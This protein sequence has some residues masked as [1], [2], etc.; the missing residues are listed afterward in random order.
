MSSEFEHFW[1]P[2]VR[3]FQLICV[4]HYSVFR[5][6]LRASP[7]SKTIPFLIYFCVFA[8]VHLTILFSKTS[9][10]G[11][12]R[13]KDYDK[14]FHGSPLMYYVNAFSV[15]GAYVTNIT[16]HLENVFCGKR[17]V[18]ICERFQA[19]SDIFEIRLNYAM[20]YKSW[21]AKYLRICGFFLLITL[22]ASITSF[23]KL[24][25]F[26]NDKYFMTPV[27]VIGTIITRARWCQ[28][29]LYLNILGD[30]LYH[31]QLSLK[32]HQLRSRSNPSDEQLHSFVR[33]NICYFR[34]IYSHCCA[35]V[36]MMSE[37]FGWSLI[38]LII[39]TTLESINGSYWLYVN[40]NTFDSAQLKIRKFI[41]VA[42]QYSILSTLP[43]YIFRLAVV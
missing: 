29:A 42:I 30:I 32:Q 39:K 21:R 16:I 31:L 33:E 18:E 3:I 12:F 35:I 43:L 11:S 25:H 10:V 19:I 26:F 36:T 9:R 37:Y 38:A 13:S 27:M 28:I 15:F 40:Q 34:E 41:C 23:S 17:E 8:A 24:P 1:K 22:M 14:S 6:H 4:S 2:F 7:Y 20:K 5:L